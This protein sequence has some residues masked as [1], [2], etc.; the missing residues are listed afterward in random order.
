MDGATHDKVP[1]LGLLTLAGAALALYAPVVRAYVQGQRGD[2]ALWRSGGRP[3]PCAARVHA[4]A[5]VHGIVAE[6]TQLAIVVHQEARIEHMHGVRITPAP[7]PC[8]P[9]LPWPSV[10][11]L[12]HAVP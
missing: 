2:Q 1:V 9:R 5:R 6:H 8:M 10:H 7:A 12:Y 11:H 4:F 3:R